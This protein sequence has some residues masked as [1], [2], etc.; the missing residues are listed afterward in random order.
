MD[1][2]SQI[3][4]GIYDEYPGDI[5]RK[6][7]AESVILMVLGGNGGSGF[8]IATIDPLINKKLPHLLRRLA[9]DIA[10]QIMKWKKYRNNE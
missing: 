3:G 1:I 8:S 5:L 9:D 6:T 10:K 7:K 2:K 4:G